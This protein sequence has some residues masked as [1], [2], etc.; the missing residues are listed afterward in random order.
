M[1]AFAAR[2]ARALALSAL[3][4]GAALGGGGALAE[5]GHRFFLV[6]HLEE[7]LPTLVGEPVRFCDKLVKVW[8][9]QQDGAPIRFDTHHFRCAVPADKSEEIAL[10]RELLQQQAGQEG[11]NP[12]AVPPLVVIS[13]TVVRNPLHGAPK[14]E[15]KSEGRAEDE[16]II[17]V[18][19]VEKP[20]ER[21]QE[22]PY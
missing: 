16:L 13:G 18:D 7:A 20:R 10:I 8:E 17:L 3:L 4:A 1:A 15:S 21:F 14:D 19:K 6:D 5:G 22:E 9:H 2:A 12:V 11:K